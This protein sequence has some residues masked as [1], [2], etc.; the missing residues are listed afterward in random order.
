MVLALFECCLASVARLLAVSALART[1]GSLIFPP[2]KPRTSESV[3]GVG[4]K[5]ETARQAKVLP[6]TVV[7][8]LT[9]CPFVITCGFFKDW[10][11]P[12]TAHTFK[13]IRLYYRKD[14]KS[15]SHHT[16]G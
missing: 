13:A 6:R 8:Q 14:L 2:L 4:E 1:R 16:S 3:N 5:F 15:T 10:H 12:H 11:L 9:L 7:L